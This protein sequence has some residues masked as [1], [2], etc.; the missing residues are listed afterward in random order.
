ML[1]LNEIIIR[2]R[3]KRRFLLLSYLIVITGFGILVVSR[4][5]S[6]YHPVFSATD[7]FVVF[8]VYQFLF[9]VAYYWLNVSAVDE[10]ESRTRGMLLIE[11][12]HS[13]STGLYQCDGLNEIQYS[14]YSRIVELMKSSIPNAYFQLLKLSPF[15]TP[16]SHSISEVDN[17][18]TLNQRFWKVILSSAFTEQVLV[19]L[20]TQQELQLSDADAHAK[21]LTEIIG[22]MKNHHK[23]YHES[24]NYVRLHNVS[25]RRTSRS[26]LWALVI[27]YILSFVASITAFA[28]L[29]IT[30]YP[31]MNMM[32]RLSMLFAF[33]GMIILQWL[34]MG[35][36]LSMP[37]DR[38]V[39]SLVVNYAVEDIN[40]ISHLLFLIPTFASRSSTIPLSVLVL[41]STRNL[42]HLIEK[43]PNP[44]ILM[45]NL[46]L[47][48]KFFFGQGN[49]NLLDGY[50]SENPFVYQIFSE[51][52]SALKHNSSA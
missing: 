33:F 30:L 18:A 22:S 43:C 19:F 20:N 51:L 11:D 14:L 49:S 37:A 6:K 2:T 35:A 27:V 17:G 23:A 7:L 29:C 40:L 42:C 21:E 44:Y 41:L 48:S 13:L 47:L 26:A 3:R 25:Q 12:I 24:V 10:V 38:I 36:I 8:S 31:T 16:D 9:I 32:E 34:F 52:S 15:Q 5:I 50:N 4:F 1:T 28:F 46:Q 39:R 45:V